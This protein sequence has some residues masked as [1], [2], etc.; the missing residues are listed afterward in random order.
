MHMKKLQ[1]NCRAEQQ[2]KCGL[3]RLE[4]KGHSIYT[5]DLHLNCVF[6]LRG[7]WVGQSISLLLP[8]TGVNQLE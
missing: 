1:N 7:D 5:L 8:K 3:S 2:Q 4:A 6:I